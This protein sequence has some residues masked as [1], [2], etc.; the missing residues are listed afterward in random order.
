IPARRVAIAR[1]D[2][3]ASGRPSSVAE[4]LTRAGAPV[5]AAAGV[6]MALEPGHGSTAVPVRT[7]IASAV[8]SMIA[9]S[10]AFTFGAS[11]DR[12][13]RTPR[14]FGQQ[15][16]ADVDAQF[17]TLFPDRLGYANNPSYEAVAAGVYGSG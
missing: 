7:V 8:V 13:V 12:A 2:A 6:R 11:L 9:L 3:V 15:W 17:D 1:L 16:D 14:I 4:G 10:A 5:P